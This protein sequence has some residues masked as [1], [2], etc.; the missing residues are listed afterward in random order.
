MLFRDQMEELKEIIRKVKSLDPEVIEEKITTH[1]EQ[2]H[3][4]DVSKTPCNEPIKLLLTVISQTD[5]T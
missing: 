1:L 5:I 4:V 3:Q 2:Q